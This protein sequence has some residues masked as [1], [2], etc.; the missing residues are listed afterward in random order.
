MLFDNK[1]ALRMTKSAG[2]G[3]VIAG[4]IIILDERGGIPNYLVVYLLEFLVSVLV[5]GG[6]IIAAIVFI[7]T[8]RSI[9]RSEEISVE[10]QKKL[11]ERRDEA[12]QKIKADSKDTKAA[13][14]VARITLEQYF[15]RNL[16]QV[17]Q[18]FVV[19]IVVML[20]GFGFV[21]FGVWTALNH[22]KEPLG[23][24]VATLSGIV[25]QFIGL[26]FMQIH[27]ATMQQANRYV[28]V[29]DRINVVGMSV[30]I[31]E[32]IPEDDPLSVQTRAEMARL[33]LE[34]INRPKT[35]QSGNFV[36]SKRG[37]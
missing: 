17:R 33:L 5:V 6:L 31:V 15:N 25:S 22:P 19:A 26:T 11:L 32:S 12:E 9:A 37:K 21:I 29:L 2:V 35:A 1:N 28:D 16:Q 30:Q 24:I 7:R 20:V 27:K 13:W 3:A 10:S 23:P 34:T 14:D 8:T 18:I 36:Q 4:G